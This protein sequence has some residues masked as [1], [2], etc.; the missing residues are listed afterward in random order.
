MIRARRIVTG[1]GVSAVVLAVGAVDLRT[2]T[3]W[4][5]T[6][7]LVLLLVRAL[8]EVYG[9]QRSGGIAA[10]PVAGATCTAAALCVR[11]LAE[12]LGLTVLE[13]RSLA[14]ALLACSAVAPI[15]LAIARP[16]A[17]GGPQPA[18]LRRVVATVFPVVWVGLLGGFMLELRLVPGETE[19]GL[20][21]GLALLLL[22]VAGVKIGDSAAY[23]VGRAIG[24]RPM[25]WVSPKKTWEGGLASVVATVAITVALGTAFGFDART[26]AVFGVVASLAGQGGDLAESWVKRAVG[27]KDAASMFGELGGV[28]DMIDALLLAA[29]VTFLF[30][31]LILLRGRLG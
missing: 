7:L 26:M 22:L 28:L 14:V 17:P 20:P 15:A 12:P 27:E 24:R 13:A 3:P 2:G 19:T 11:A 30:V 5:T 4:A 31:E 9:L 29:P 21:R 23:F 10:H 18:D 25:S 16:P 8:I 1:L 6:A